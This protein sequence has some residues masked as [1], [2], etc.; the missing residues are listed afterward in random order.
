MGSNESDSVRFSILKLMDKIL[1]SKKKLIGKRGSS[2]LG[3]GNNLD[4]QL[5]GLNFEG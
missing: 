1:N 3:R 2:S 5:L 4:G